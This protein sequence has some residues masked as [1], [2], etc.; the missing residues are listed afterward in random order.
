MV[1]NSLRSDCCSGIVVE[2]ASGFV[3]AVGFVVFCAA[4]FGSVIYFVVLALLF[5]LCCF[6]FCLLKIKKKAKR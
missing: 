3:V 5:L 4:V 1:A 6:G 2:F